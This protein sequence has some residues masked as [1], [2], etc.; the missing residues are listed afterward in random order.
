M[1]RSHHRYSR[2]FLALVFVMVAAFNVSAQAFEDLNLIDSPTAG[3]IPHGSYLLEGSIGP[4][5][6]LLFGVKVGFHDRLVVGASFG[7]QEFI[8][9]G[10]IDVNDKP[11]FH[12]RFRIL[13]ESMAGP[14]LAIGID[15]QGEEAYDES[16]GRYERK[17]KGIFGAMSKNYYYYRNISFHGGV[18]YSLEDEF[19]DGIDFFVGMSLEVF[20]GMTLLLDYNAAMNDDNGDLPSCRTEGKGYLDTGVRFDYR[21]NLRIRILFR[22]LIENY[23]RDDGVARSIEI[24]FIDYF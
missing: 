23:K 8:G 13:D 5:S 4:N 9:R 19:E 17:S 22:D 10:D 7:I 20:T 1:L 6:G 24:M 14:A 16:D 15:T 11:G 2:V 18:N 3:I 12:A 21:D